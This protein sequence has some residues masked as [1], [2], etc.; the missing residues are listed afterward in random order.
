[1]KDNVKRKP[2]VG[3]THHRFVDT[4]HLG[5]WLEMELHD[6]RKGYKE[7]LLSLLQSA[8]CSGSVENGDRSAMKMICR[9]LLENFYHI[10]A[11]LVF[12]F[13]DTGLSLTQHNILPSF[14]LSLV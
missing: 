2:G 11:R 8:V 10:C 13:C 7:K 5:K 1:M 3:F 4:H 6:L 12:Y 9:Q 14:C